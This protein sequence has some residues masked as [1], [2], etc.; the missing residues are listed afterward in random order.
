MTNIRYGMLDF[1]HYCWVLLCWVLLPV[2]LL[3]Q[4]FLLSMDGKAFHYYCCYLYYYSNYL[5]NCFEDKKRP[6]YTTFTTTSTTLSTAAK[7]DLL[8]LLLL[9]PLLLLLF[10]LKLRW[11]ARRPANKHLLRLTTWP[12]HLPQPHCPF[13]IL[14]IITSSFTIAFQNCQWSV[15]V[16][17][18]SNRTEERLKLKSDISIKTWEEPT[19]VVAEITCWW[20]L[21]VSGNWFATSWSLYRR[22]CAINT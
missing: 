20:L 18:L 2:A 10:L 16:P 15:K 21:S 4:L 1:H 11:E 19:L 12:P 14:V 8:L 9:F 3:L 17:D 6:P 5:F 22:F 7:W 13:H